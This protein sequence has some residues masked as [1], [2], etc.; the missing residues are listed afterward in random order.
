MGGNSFRKIRYFLGKS[1]FFT[2]ITQF[3]RK[4]LIS[5]KKTH[6]FRKGA[7][8][9]RILRKWRTF[10]MGRICICFQE[11]IKSLRK[12]YKIIKFPRKTHIFRKRVS[13]LWILRK[14]RTFPMGRICRFSQEFTKIPRKTLNSTKHAQIHKILMKNAHVQKSP[15]KNTQT[16]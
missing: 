16:H 6:V 3:R 13:F 4:M 14:W 7:S 10:P 5:V 15:R 1:L 9:L 11:F 12:T 2:K 8:C